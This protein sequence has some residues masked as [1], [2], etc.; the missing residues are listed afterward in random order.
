ML[1]KISVVMPVWNGEKYLRPAVDTILAQTF[2]DFELVVVDDGSTDGT[3]D[4]LASF[5]DSRI[6]LCRLE[7]GGIVTALNAGVAAARAEWI[8]RQDADDLSLPSRLQAQW[9]AVKTNKDVVLCFSD[10]EL[11]GD[12]AREA[13]RARFPRTRALLA[14]RLCFQSPIIHSTVLFRKNTFLRAEGYLPEERHAEDFGLWGRMLPLGDFVPV[15]ERLLQFRMHAESVSKGNLQKQRS[16]AENIAV[17][18]CQRFMRLTEHEARRAFA[19]LSLSA[20][21]RRWNDWRWFVSYCVPR[22]PWQSN[23]TR[24]WLVLQSLK[25][26]ATRRP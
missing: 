19:V 25:M 7:H 14:L 16:L 8:A 5:T 23:E 4:I 13:L 20:R 10:A 15:R 11:I 3:L 9:D 1:P 26:L 22:L 24:A 6:R 18:N 12:G 2:T 17:K 21:Q